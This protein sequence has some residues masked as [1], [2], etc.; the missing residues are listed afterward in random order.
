MPHTH[1]CDEHQG[2]W[3]HNDDSCPAH[4]RAR[5]QCDDC[6]HVEIIEAR[7]VDRKDPT[8]RFAGGRRPQDGR[9]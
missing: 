9:G 4:G 8:R 5:L 7:H 3:V 6:G 1:Y 2:N